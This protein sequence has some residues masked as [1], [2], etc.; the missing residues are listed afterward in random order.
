MGERIG[1]FFVQNGMMDTRQVEIVIQKQRAGDKRVFGVIALKLGY[2]TEDAL[3]VY[4]D[5]LERQLNALD[6][7]QI[8]R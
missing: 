8:P 6:G 1:E 4:V 7:S 2:I 3:K 5:H